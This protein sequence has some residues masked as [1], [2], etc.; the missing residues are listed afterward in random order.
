MKRLLLASAAMLISGV[1]FAA[2]PVVIEPIPALAPV[3]AVVDWTGLYV[4]L[5]GGYAWGDYDFDYDPPDVGDDADGWLLG[6][7]IGANYQWNWLVVGAEVDLAWADIDGSASCP[8][9][10][11]DC[12]TEID[13]F[14]T[15]RGRLGVAAGRF[16]VF[17]TGGLAMGGVEAQTVSLAGGAIPPS[18]TPENGEDKTAVG[19]TAGAG[20]EVMFGN[21]WTAK[22]DWLYYDLGDDSYDIDNG[23]VVDVQHTGSLFRLHLT[24]LF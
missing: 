13:W 17:G 12:E 8:N 15:V 3:P 4:G 14:S 9:P 22:A 1:A 24:K 2:D 16:H 5:N 7:E 20:A 6:A 21:R 10:A 18:G 11:F 23:I 19:W